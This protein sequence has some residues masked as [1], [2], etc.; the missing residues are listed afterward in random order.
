MKT[1]VAYWSL[2]GNTKRVAEA[3]FQALPG[4]KIIKPMEEVDSLDAVDLTFVGFPIMQFGVPRAVRKF[5]SGQCAGKRVA[6]FVTHA[7]QSNSDDPQQQ[8]MLA[9]ELE[10]C[11]TACVNSNLEGL[12]HCQGELSEKT[13]A[14]L[15]ESNIPMLMKFAGM[16]PST[17]GHPN[18]EELEQAQAFAGTI[19]K[20]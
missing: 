15:M 16:R 3:I 19:V 4:D 10:K 17:I 2:T 8:E 7:M 9:N 5:L 14:E 20:S 1:L 12:F 13:A 18:L 11:R 6:L